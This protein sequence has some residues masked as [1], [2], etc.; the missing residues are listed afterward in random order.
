MAIIQRTFTYRGRIKVSTQDL[1]YAR[2]GR[3]TCTIRVGKIGVAGSEITL[4]DGVGK[5]KVEITA[6]DSTKLYSELTDRDAAEEGFNSLDEL[7]HDLSRYYGRIDPNQ[8]ITVIRFRKV[9][10]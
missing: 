6:V 3:K 9:A 8:P 5:L 2:T 7:S 1:E 4:T 10:T